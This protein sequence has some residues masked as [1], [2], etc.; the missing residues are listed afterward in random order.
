MARTR[1]AALR[2][3]AVTALIDAPL[4][5]LRHRPSSLP[6]YAPRYDPLV[7]AF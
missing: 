4:P 1:H 2:N 7:D 6:F 5:T 3:A